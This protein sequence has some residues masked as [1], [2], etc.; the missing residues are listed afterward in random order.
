MGFPRN[1]H[2]LRQTLTL[3]LVLVSLSCSDDGTEPQ[4]DLAPLVGTWQANTLLLT[5]QANPSV[6]VDLVEEGA[7]FILS[8]LSTGQY[9]A[10]LSAFGIAN[11]EVGTITVSGN[12]AT[13]T[14]TSP[15]GP[16]IVSIWSFQGSALVLDGESVFDFN[17]DGEV[18]PSFILIILD[19]LDP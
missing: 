15:V 19:P 11:T 8:I 4:A 18:E 2:S 14:P 10:S 9:S 16:P 5:N 6:S 13:I 17:Q 1:S 7:D 3:L 12:E